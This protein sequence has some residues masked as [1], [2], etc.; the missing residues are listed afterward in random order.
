MNLLRDEVESV[1][2]MTD[3]VH[4]RQLAAQAVTSYQRKQLARMMTQSDIDGRDNGLRVDY[5]RR[6]VVFHRVTWLGRLLRLFK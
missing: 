6:A 5:S 2:P 1:E 4:P 3:Y